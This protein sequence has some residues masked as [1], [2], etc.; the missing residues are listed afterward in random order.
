MLGCGAVKYCTGD[1]SW[2]DG[3]AMHKHYY[4]Q[5]LPNSLTH[6]FNKQPDLY[7]K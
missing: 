3:T 7:V 1:H 5:P 2:R 4:T 6:L